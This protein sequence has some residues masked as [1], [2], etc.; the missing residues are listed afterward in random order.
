VHREHKTKRENQQD[1][2]NLIINIKLVASCWFSLFTL[3]YSMFRRYVL[4]PSSDGW[5]CYLLQHFTPWTL[6]LSNDIC[7]WSGKSKQKFV[8]TWGWKQQYIQKRWSTSAELLT[9]ALQMTGSSAVLLFSSH[10]FS[11]PHILFHFHFTLRL[12]LFVVLHLFHFLLQSGVSS[13]NINVS[14]NAGRGVRVRACAVGDSS[15]GGCNATCRKWHYARNC[16]FKSTKLWYIIHPIIKLWI[17]RTDSNQTN[18]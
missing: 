6:C 14:L 3:Q 16:N 9:F 2:T 13:Y 8:A 1:A 18:K 11:L 7:C 10:L 12:F 15:F 5:H 4:P 17:L